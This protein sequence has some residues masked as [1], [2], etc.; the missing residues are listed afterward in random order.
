M[1]SRVKL[2]LMACAS[3][4]LILT[5]AAGKPPAPPAKNPG[6]EARFVGRWMVTF[7]NGVVE[8][9]EVRNDGSAS[10]SET[11]RSSDGQV[12]QQTDSVI[13][14]FAD[15]RVERWTAVGRRMVVEHWFPAAGYPAGNRVLGIADRVQCQ[16]AQDD[17]SQQDLQGLQGSWV[18]GTLEENGSAIPLVKPLPGG[19]VQR[20]MIVLTFR[21]KSFRL[22]D[23]DK[24]WQGTFSIDSKAKPKTMDFT[25]T[26]F[27]GPSILPEQTLIARAIY[28]LT[29]KTLKVR[30]GP[31][32]APIKKTGSIAYV[33]GETRPKDFGPRPGWETI[34][35]HRVPDMPKKND[36]T[37]GGDHLE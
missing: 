33:W 30:H 15:D 22:Q 9:C 36:S 37:A 35:Y 28:D 17:S 21:D 24:A 13:I 2:L 8:S 32:T 31:K 26:R 4:T 34:V 5:S 14:T 25:W 3:L 23:G 20:R 16:G 19:A 11:L 6:P 29:G 10:E 12:S 1:M 7:A 18:A 27:G